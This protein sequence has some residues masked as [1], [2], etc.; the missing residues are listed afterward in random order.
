MQMKL[1][2]TVVFALLIIGKSYS[3]Q[4]P[5]TSLSISECDKYEIIFKGKIISVK[6]CENSFGEA[7]F[8][9]EELYKGNATK[10][11]KVLF[12]C[13]GSCD[14]KFSPKE[15]WIIYSRYKQINNALMD[16][17]SRSRKWFKIDKQDFYATNFGNSYEEEIKFLRSNLGTHRLVAEANNSTEGRNIRPS[18][19]QTI[20]LLLSSIAAIFLFYWLFNRAFKARQRRK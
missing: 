19:T 9:V 18:A 2:Y 13:G 5:E 14:M 10:N 3:C 17:C 7:I 12:T 20:I 15:E 16:W 11:F 8:E 4:C 6:T 1:F